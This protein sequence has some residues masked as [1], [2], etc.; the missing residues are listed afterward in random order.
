MWRIYQGGDVKQIEEAAR[1]LGTINRG[2]K[3]YNQGEQ[4]GH[5]RRQ[6]HL[7]QLYRDEILRVAPQ[8]TVVPAPPSMRRLRADEGRPRCVGGAQRGEGT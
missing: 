8:L 6:E 1:G 7:E 4:D 2:T 5:R 3:G